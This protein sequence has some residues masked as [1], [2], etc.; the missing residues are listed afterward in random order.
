MYKKL[1]NNTTI[2]IILYDKFFQRTKI[3]FYIIPPIDLR[4]FR[5]ICIVMIGSGNLNNI[6]LDVE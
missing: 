4:K 6:K 3:K 5:Q 1:L 2:Y